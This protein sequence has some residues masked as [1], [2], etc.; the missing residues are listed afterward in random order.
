MDSQAR[1]T[2]RW[3]RSAATPLVLNGVAKTVTATFPTDP[4]VAIAVGGYAIVGTREYLMTLAAQDVSGATIVGPGAPSFTVTS[5]SN[6]LAH[7]L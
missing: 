5:E 6:A 2:D 7:A 1:V 4:H 3:F